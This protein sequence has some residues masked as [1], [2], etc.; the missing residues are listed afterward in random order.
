MTI[1]TKSFNGL[2]ALKEH[3]KTHTP[4]FYHSSRTSTVIPYDKL[5]SEFKTPLVVGDLSRIPGE[6][7]MHGDNLVIRGAVNWQEADQFLKARGRAIMT[8]PTEQL[9]LV[10]A[11]IAT[12]CTGERC[13]AFGNMR[14]QVVRLKYLDFNGVEREL[15]A[16]RPF[17][18]VDGLADYQNA[19]AAYRD[20]KNAPFPRF[21]F[22]TDL[23]IGT[24]GQLGIVT[25]VELMTTAHDD[26]THLFM[27]LPR[28]EENFAPHMEIYQS[29]QHFRGAV[30]SCELLDANCMAYLK[31]DERLGVNQDV[32]FL[33]ILSADFERVYGEL[34]GELKLTS[35]DNVFE[36]TSAKFH[37]VRAGVPR[38]VFEENSKMGVKKMGT[39]CQ[40][41][42]THFQALME[43]YRDLA[44]MGVRYNL[45]GHFGDAHLHYNYMPR[46]EDTARCQAEF[47][48]LYARVLSWHGSPF[49]EHG[50]G[51]LKQK[52][53][54]PF[55][56]SEQRRTWKA[57]KLTHDPHGQFFPAGFMTSV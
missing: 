12:S 1:Q 30:I 2:E 15:H 51:L 43:T 49:A 16:D 48:K 5:E 44:K 26:V 37:S 25:E 19:F 47:E 56:S 7:K 35:P 20:Y 46:P 6:M 40:V 27:L 42:P 10:L 3:L 34:L 8:S 21:E 50:I 4:T 33:E 41:A 24:E 45:F 11:G 22:E 31:P 14:R 18:T 52:F 36:I 38:G 29:V 23:L 32:I 9:A 54:K 28:W 39:D 53:I 13:F 57:L 55:I 17:P